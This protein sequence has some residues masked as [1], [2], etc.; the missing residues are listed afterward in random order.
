MKV[1][2]IRRLQD[3]FQVFLIKLNHEKMI[4]LLTTRFYIKTNFIKT[5]RLKVAK[6]EQ[7]NSFMTEVPII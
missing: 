5:T 3:L 6:K 4:D 7:Y 1:N 2:T